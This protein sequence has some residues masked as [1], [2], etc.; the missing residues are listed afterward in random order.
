MVLSTRAIWKRTKRIVFFRRS[1]MDVLK[2]I[3]TVFLIF[4][5][6]IIKA[7]QNIQGND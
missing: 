5:P 4:F 7:Q 2:T 6:A 1:R 3:I